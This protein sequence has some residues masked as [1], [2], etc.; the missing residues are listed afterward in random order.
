VFGASARP[1]SWRWRGSASVILP[2]LEPPAGNRSGR[3][4]VV[5]IMRR[6]LRIFIPLLCF[7]LVVA[8]NDGHS[9]SDR[10]EPE[11]PKAKQQRNSGPEQTADEAGVYRA[12]PPSSVQATADGHS[13]TI[14][15]KNFFYAVDFVVLRRAVDEQSRGWV[16]L[17]VVPNTNPTGPP[18]PFTFTDV[19]AQPGVTYVYGVKSRNLDRAGVLVESRVIETAPVTIRQ[20][21]RPGFE[22]QPSSKR[23][24]ILNS[25]SILN[26]G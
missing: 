4:F 22:F 3:C 14:Q 12:S 8:C 25:P 16:Q 6:R 15:W 9:A 24:S 19:S 21:G 7:A 11:R 10:Q 23:P 5:D 1:R 2:R 20:L 17:G 18:P 13:I 26:I